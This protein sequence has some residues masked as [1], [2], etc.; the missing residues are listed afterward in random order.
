[1]HNFNLNHITKIEGHA[2]L[3]LQIKR[4]KVSRCDLDSVEG[5]R[6]FEGLL[7][8]RHF[9]ETAEI[10]S[11]ICGICSCAHT[12]AA[13]MAIENA[14]K[15]RISPQTYSLRKLLTIG[16]RIR[17]HATHLYFM[18]LPDYLGYESALEMVHRHKNEIKRA[19]RLMKLGNEMVK[20][21]A[22]RDLHP[23]SATIGGALKIPSSEEIASTK[24][25]LESL[26]S[27]AVKT[28]ILFGKLKYPDYATA[29]E[30]FSVHNKKEYGIL[31]GSLISKNN[32]YSK[33]NYL[34]Y[35][36]EYHEPDSTANFV[37]KEGKSYMVGALARI[38]NNHTQISKDARKLLNKS[39]IK[40]PNHNP[41]ANN[42]AQAIELVHYIDEGIEICNG[43]KPRNEPI[44]KP[45]VKAGRGVSAIEAPRGIL[46]HD[47]TLDK[48]GNI[49]SANII[50]PTAQN[51][52][53][54]QDDIRSY[55]STIIKYDKHK[56]VHEV[57]K[58]IRAYDPCF[59]CSTHFL[60]VKWL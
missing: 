46:F 55:V 53:S 43:L 58:L 38:N 60:K 34:H 59:S 4:G 22:G 50:T 29:S 35:L 52:R 32:E 16:E 42:F 7:K 26:K 19:L 23:V 15:L 8:D 10:T 41:F 37:V 25:K 3:T 13:I 31:E 48:N 24:D 11:R 1:M 51:L 47:Y 28:A 45:K 54:M 56:I 6:Y 9:T 44:I 12:I 39:K 57:E 27:D 5:S 18:A 40:F 2:S 20:L 30:C 49:S 17:S 14:L 33:D 36:R 21:F